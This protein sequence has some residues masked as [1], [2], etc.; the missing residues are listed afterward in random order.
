MTGKDALLI[1]GG[2]LVGAALAVEARRARQAADLD[3]R[4]A[5]VTGGSRGLGLLIA[6]ELGEQGAKVVLLARDQVELERAEHRLR[7]AGVEVSVIVADLSDAAAAEQA[8]ETVV[9]RHGAIDVLVN[10]AGII[11]VGPLQ[12]ATVEDFEASMAVHFW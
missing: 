3:G 12:H 9:R 6:R 8:I 11:T 5:L 1:A 7:E 4:V 2:V 10:N